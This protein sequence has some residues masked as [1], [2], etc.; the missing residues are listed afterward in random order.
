MHIASLLY[1]GPLHW[2]LQML[3]CVLSCNQVIIGILANPRSFKVSLCVMECWVRMSV[4]ICGHWWDGSAVTW[5][6]WAEKAGNC[7][8]SLMKNSA[9]TWPVP[10]THSERLILGTRRSAWPTFP[11][12]PLC[13]VR[14]GGR[15]TRGEWADLYGGYERALPLWNTGTSQH[16]QTVMD[17]HSHRAQCL[18]LLM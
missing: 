14:R 2:D 13:H 15:E 12:L 3:K 7:G 11:R 4:W 6:P 18:T 5:A 17:R 10:L 9:A 1:R 16:T 8:M